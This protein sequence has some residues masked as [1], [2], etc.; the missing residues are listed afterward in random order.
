MSLIRGS[1]LAWLADA[2]CPPHLETALRLTAIA[3]LLRPMGPWFVRPGILALAAI[4][5]VSP[6]L[7]RTPAVWAAMSAFQRLAHEAVAAGWTK[8]EVERALFNL[9]KPHNLSSERS[10]RGNRAQ[11]GRAIARLRTG[12]A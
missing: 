6:R 12:L 2:R 7:L 5:L 8:Q 1:K 9:S 3:L 11:Q 4:V 10:K